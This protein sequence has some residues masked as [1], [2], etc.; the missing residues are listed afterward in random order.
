MSS[1]ANAILLFTVAS[2]LLNYVRQAYF[3]IPTL[4]MERNSS[5]ALFQTHSLLYR[6]CFVMFEFKAVLKF[7]TYIRIEYFARHIGHDV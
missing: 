4:A 1:L 2:K 6:I 7:Y 5:T 3:V